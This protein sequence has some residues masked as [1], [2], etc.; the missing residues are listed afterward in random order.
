MAFLPYNI[1]TF[2]Q[3]NKFDISFRSNLE[4][5]NGNGNSN[6]APSGGVAE[7]SN[8]EQ[9]TSPRLASFSP[10]DSLDSNLTLVSGVGNVNNAN[11]N[12]AA[13]TLISSVERNGGGKNPAVEKTFSDGSVE[14]V[15]ANGNR[16][17]VLTSF[18]IAPSGNTTK[19]VATFHFSL[20]YSEISSKLLDRF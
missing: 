12:A 5:N 13:V 18:R 19:Y 4:N 2:K 10:A 6:A 8:K 3:L 14:I 20:P 11:S 9:M 7:V 1:V 15:Y 17:G 16:D